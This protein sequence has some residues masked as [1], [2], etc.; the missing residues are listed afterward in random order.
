MTSSV[1]P[2]NGSAPAI[3]SIQSEVAFGHVGNSAAVLPLQRL[4]FEVWPINTVQLGHHP[5][6]GRFKGHIVEPERLTVILEGVLERA[7][8][9]DCV[10]MLSGYLGDAR[11]AGLVTRALGAVQAAG[12]DPVYLMDPVIGDD[13]PGVFVRPDI[14]GVIKRHL[15]PHTRI[16]TPN[17]FELA[18]LTGH[19]VVDLADARQAAAILLAH[20]PDLVVVTGLELADHPQQLS[21]LAVTADQA[22]LVRT[23]RLPTSFSGTG[24][25]FS[26]LFLGH[27]LKAPDLKTAFERAISAIF[28]LV[29]LTYQR[30]NSELGLIAAQDLLAAPAIRFSAEELA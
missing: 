25:A 20:G 1:Q 7:P 6:Y 15:L 9:T 30:G 16:V 18:H 19:D 22:W 4:G 13:G 23:P 3:L 24:D 2:L 5:G 10:G 27:Y 29:E 26:A 8:L 17:R 11:V 28:S 12:A 21:L 14:P